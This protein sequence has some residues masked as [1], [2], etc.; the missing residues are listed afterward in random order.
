MYQWYKSFGD[1]PT[2]LKL[3]SSE[4]G[5]KKG[6]EKAQITFLIM[7]GL[8][9]I[10]PTHEKKRISEAKGGFTGALGTVNSWKMNL[11][12]KAEIRKNCST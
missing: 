8:Y 4:E 3:P 6:S 10:L 1:F 12:I 2:L 7:E 9:T 11:I 5:A